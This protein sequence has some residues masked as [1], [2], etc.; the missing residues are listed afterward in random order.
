MY[1]TLRLRKKMKVIIQG[2]ESVLP[3]NGLVGYLPVFETLE[4][5]KNEAGNEAEVLK[6]EID[7]L[8]KISE[9]NG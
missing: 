7:P 8:M 4:E 2:S 1:V 5:A 6:L 9:D 3:V